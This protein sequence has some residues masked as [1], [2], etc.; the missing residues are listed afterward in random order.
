MNNS[1]VA[2]II[3]ALFLAIKMT[4]KYKDPNT[5]QFI[6]DAVVVFISS[7]AAL[8]GIERYVGKPMGP[9]IAT[10]FIETPSF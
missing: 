1:I 3:G 5:K 7:M 8:Y 9:K 4:L 10:V 6:Q 2:A